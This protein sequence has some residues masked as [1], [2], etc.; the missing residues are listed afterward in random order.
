M[1]ASV[2]LVSLPVTKDNILCSYCSR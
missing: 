2:D 1:P